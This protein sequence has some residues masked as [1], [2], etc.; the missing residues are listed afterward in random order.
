MTT[1]RDKES[2][3][4]SITGP[5]TLLCEFIGDG[6]EVE[7]TYDGNKRSV[8]EY[9]IIAY[10]KLKKIKTGSY[11]FFDAL[12]KA[13]GSE[14]LHGRAFSIIRKTQRSPYLIKEVANVN[15][16]GQKHI[17]PPPP[18]PSSVPQVVQEMMA[19][20]RSHEEET[21]ERAAREAA[22]PEA[23]MQAMKSA[24]DGRYFRPEGSVPTPSVDTPP[25][26]ARL[27][28]ERL[29]REVA[30]MREQKASEK[31]H[32][33]VVIACQWR[34]ETG[35]CGAGFF[36]PKKVTLGMMGEK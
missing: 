11:V 24:E 9:D 22:E 17:V 16:P 8:T 26:R 23:V 3:Y 18:H 36:C 13:A 7:T 10:K 27:A 33:G 6:E 31:D 35:E 5:C 1:W 4:I 14:S 29:A 28:E 32:C 2:P 12:K 20:V 25:A 21:S 15:D 30:T 19:P 34:G